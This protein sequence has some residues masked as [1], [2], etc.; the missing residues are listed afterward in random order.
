ML[1]ITFF[2]CV[3]IFCIHIFWMLFRKKFKN[4]LFTVVYLK[5]H[6]PH[7]LHVWI[8]SYILTLMAL[9]VVLHCI[10]N[11]CFI[12]WH[13]DVYYKLCLYFTFT[14]PVQVSGFA[15]KT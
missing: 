10:M 8:I 9:F 7:D 4:H 14:C 1:C 12:L 2:S 13:K 15:E 5:P 6:T 3:N 11:Q